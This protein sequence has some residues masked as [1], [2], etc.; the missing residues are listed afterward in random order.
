MLFRSGL[1]TQKPSQ[2]TSFIK[3]SRS[4]LLLSISFLINSITTEFPIMSTNEETIDA[5]KRSRAK[6]AARDGRLTFR[7]F[8][9]GQMRRE[10]KDAAVE[11]CNPQIQ[12]F[13]KCAQ[14]QGLMVVFNCQHKK[15]DINECMFIHNS[16][17][18]FQKY[19]LANPEEVSRRTKGMAK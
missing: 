5:E 3:S 8:A 9:E 14:E 18:A 13:A 4:Y 6:A 2:N 7:N 1:S 17:D 12:E 19:L 16:D 15:K 10:F 11:V